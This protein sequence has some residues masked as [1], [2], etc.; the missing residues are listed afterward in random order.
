MGGHIERV[1]KKYS[2]KLNTASHN[3]ASCYTALDRFLE[4]SLSQESL[5]YKG[6]PSRDFWVS[7]HS[8]LSG[9]V[10]PP[11]LFFCFE[12]VVAIQGLLLFR[13]NFWNICFSSVKYT[14]G[15]LIGITLT[16]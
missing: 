12:I 14:F 2:L 13:M 9:S 15:T 1:F 10:I 8:L 11:I 4:H 16:L 3:N 6:L 5:Y 7:P